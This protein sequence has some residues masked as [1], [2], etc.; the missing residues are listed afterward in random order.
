[1]QRPH[2]SVDLVANPP[3]RLQVLT[4][5][6]VERPVLVALAR[7]DGACVPTPHRDHHVGGTHDLVGQRLRELLADVEPHL[8]H[9]LDDSRIDLVGRLATG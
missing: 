7:I 8:G 6:I 3:H 4:G 9:R 5:R 2:T 1:M